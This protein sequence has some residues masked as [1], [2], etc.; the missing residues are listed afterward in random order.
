MPK[1]VEDE[2]DLEFARVKAA[3]KALKAKKKCKAC[4]RSLVPVGRSRVG[5]KPH[6]DWS[7][8]Q[9]HKKCWK[10]L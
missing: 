4:G 10:E 1:K 7:T 5:G 2:F 6:K 9:Y 8:R 3:K